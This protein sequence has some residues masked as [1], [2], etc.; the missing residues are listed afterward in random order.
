[1]LGRIRTARKVFE[2]NYTLI[3]GCTTITTALGAWVTYTARQMHHRRLEAKLKELDEHISSSNFQ[4]VE[5]DA[6]AVDGYVTVKSTLSIGI[7]TVFGCLMLGYTIGVA[8]GTFRMYRR[9]QVERASVLTT[10][11]KKL[12]YQC[13]LPQMHLDTVDRALTETFGEDNFRKVR[14]LTVREDEDIVL[15]ARMRA[16]QQDRRSVT[17]MFR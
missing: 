2:E 7:P 8:H 14:I 9:A 5:P 15:R 6:D 17:N 4:R 12:A 1:M 11:R 10:L 13:S 3:S 16:P